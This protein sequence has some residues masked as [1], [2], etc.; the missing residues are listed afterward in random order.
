MWFERDGN[1]VQGSSKWQ[2]ILLY[3]LI[4]H[5][6]LRLYVHRVW[7]FCHHPNTIRMSRVW[8]V[9]LIKKK[10]KKRHLKQQRR[11]F[12]CVHSGTLLSPKDHVMH[13]H[14]PYSDVPMSNKKQTVV[15]CNGSTVTIIQW[16]LLVY[17]C[18]RD[19]ITQMKLCQWCSHLSLLL[20]TRINVCVCFIVSKNLSFC[21]VVNTEEGVS[22]CL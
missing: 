7:D 8:S 16:R 17:C 21:P 3:A 10:K 14:L 15:N 4:D 19:I 2:K 20:K 18:Y 1:T 5:R 6:W 11:T 12:I 22:E 13:P 9:V